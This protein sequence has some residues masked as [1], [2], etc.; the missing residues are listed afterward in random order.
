MEAAPS[1]SGPKERLFED[2]LR[3]CNRHE[4]VGVLSATAVGGLLVYVLRG[5]IPHATLI[6]WL[7]AVV[8]MGVIRYALL[9]R[10][11]SSSPP[12]LKALSWKAHLYIVA[13]LSGAVWGSASIFLFPLD[14]VVHEAFVA[15]TLGGMVAGAAGTLSVVMGVFVAYSAPVLIPL[16]ASFFIMGDQVR[17]SMGVMVLLYGILMFSIAKSISRTN[18]SYLEARDRAEDL[19]RK[20]QEEIAGRIRAEERR[21]KVIVELQEALAHVKTLK[22]LIPICANCKKIRDDTGYWNRIEFYL[23]KHSDVDFSH[24]IC[25]DCMQKLYP[26]YGEEPEEKE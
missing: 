20:L 24:S 25:P 12:P 5:I 6:L 26:G 9:R 16:V 2:L 10:Y 4:P 23:K 15:F 8:F 11:A 19:N 18:R 1:R 3:Q 17:I 14:S 22:G 7:L 21:E 13:L